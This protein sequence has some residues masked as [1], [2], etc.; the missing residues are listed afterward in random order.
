MQAHVA[1]WHIA[2]VHGAEMVARHPAYHDTNNCTV[3][4]LRDTFDIEL[5]TAYEHMKAHGR[6]HGRGPSRDIYWKAVNAMAKQHGFRVTKLLRRQAHRDYG[7]TVVS[8]QRNIRPNQRV[9]FNVRGH[10]MGFHNGTSDWA[11]GRR[12]H[13]RDVWEIQKAA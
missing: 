9:I 12:H 11:N 13:I 10:T 3:K 6:K 1:Q 8:A 7:K 5:I 2:K 4:A